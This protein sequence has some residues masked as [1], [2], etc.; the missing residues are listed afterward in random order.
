MLI[1]LTQ[2]K[3]TTLS[4]VEHCTVTQSLSLSLSFVLEWTQTPQT[5]LPAAAA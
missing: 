1:N 4:L 2:N 5:N 3:K